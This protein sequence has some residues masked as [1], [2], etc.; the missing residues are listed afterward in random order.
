MVRKFVLLAIIGSGL[1]LGACNTVRGAG[2][3][4][5]SAA[6]CTENMINNGQC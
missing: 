6:N 3:D 5:Q 4:L 1:S 2:Q